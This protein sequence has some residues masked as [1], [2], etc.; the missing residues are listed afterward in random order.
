MI[1]I[2][3]VKDNDIKIIE[4]SKEINFISFERKIKKQFNLDNITIKYMMKYTKK[5]EDI[6][7]LILIENDDDLHSSFK[8]ASID[9]NGMITMI[10]SRYKPY[11]ISFKARFLDIAI[12]LT[13]FFPMTL[14]MIPNLTFTCCVF[15][16]V[17]IILLLIEIP[18]FFRSYNREEPKKSNYYCLTEKDLENLSEL[19]IDDSIRLLQQY[20]GDMEK[21]ISELSKYK[22][23]EDN[24]LIRPSQYKKQLEYL[25]ELGFDDPENLNLL[26]QYNGDLEKVISKLIK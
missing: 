16:D 23:R 18:E 20:D 21:I 11:K 3:A 4:V 2:R 19:K 1:T 8:Y 10:I 6:E 9:R 22:K 12:L 5:K 13:L 17:M 26:H 24:P 7:D 15:L 25:K 14:L